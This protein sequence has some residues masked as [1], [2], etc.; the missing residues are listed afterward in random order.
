M[1]PPPFPAVREVPVG[2]VTFGGRKPLVL[3]AGPC[4][5]ESEAACLETARSLKELTESLRIPLVFKSSYDKANRSSLRSYRGPGLTRGL[6]ILGRVKGELGVPVLSDV[7]RFEEVEAA[8][9]VLDILQVPAFLCR[10]TDFVVSIARTGKGV[11]VKKG[12]FL[13]PWDVRNILEKIESTGNQSILFTERGT[14]FGYHNL[15]ADMRSLVIMREMGYPV[16]FDVTHSLQLPGGL[17]TSSGG[18]REFIS[19][20]AR[21]AVAVGIDGL[22]MEVHSNP[23]AALCDGPN[24]QPLGELRPLLRQLTEIDR[25]VKRGDGRRGTDGRTDRKA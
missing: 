1:T 2:P 15:V 4:V 6:E 24:S 22:F 17:G 18:Q 12:Q 20:L 16:I 7:H 21:A 3:I 9:G 8:A 13:A 10:Q 5:I 19:A 11:N 23:E 25:L 14:S